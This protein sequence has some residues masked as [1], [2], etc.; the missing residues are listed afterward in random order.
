MIRLLTANGIKNIKNIVRGDA[1]TGGQTGENAKCTINFTDDTPSKKILVKGC[2]GHYKH[3]IGQQIREAW[4][5][6]KIAPIM[7][8]QGFKCP[9]T[10][11]NVYDRKRARSLVFMELLDG[12]VEVALGGIEEWYDVENYVPKDAKPSGVKLDM[13]QCFDLIADQFAVEHLAFWNDK[14]FLKKAYPFLNSGSYYLQKEKA[15]YDACLTDT[16][17]VYWM[18]STI[19]TSYQK[20]FPLGAKATAQTLKN[21]SWERYQEMI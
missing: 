4:Y 13:Q 10:L 9:W 2:P 8:E 19:M 15:D 11:L 17:R 18:T 1:I 6:D 12:C 20:M 7:K 14:E 16:N 21:S 3:T 5:Y